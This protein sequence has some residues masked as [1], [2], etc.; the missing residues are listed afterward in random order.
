MNSTSEKDGD[1]IRGG[2]S[3]IGNQDTAPST[4]PSKAMQEKTL[5]DY[6]DPCYH[7]AAHR[8]CQCMGNQTSQFLMY[9]NCNEPVHLFCAKYLIEQT[10]A[11][12]HTSYISVQDFTKEGKARWKKTSS[13]DKDDVAFCILCSAKMKAVN[14]SVEANKL[15]KH[16]A[17]LGKSAPKKK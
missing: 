4:P 16:Q 8:L 3:L 14:V 13:A 11:A 9:I 10:P 7:C 15:A 5:D 12:K 17:S 1:S 2:D 6:N